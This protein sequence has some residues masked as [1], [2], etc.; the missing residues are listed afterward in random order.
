MVWNMTFIFPDIGNFIIP[1]DFHTFQ[2]GRYTT[3]QMYTGGCTSQYIG[4]IIIHIISALWDILFA[5]QFLKGRHFG[6]WTLLT[7]GDVSKIALESNIQYPT[8]NCGAKRGLTHQSST[9]KTI[10]VV[11][12]WRVHFLH[13]HLGILSPYKSEGRADLDLGPTDLDE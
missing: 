2:R 5:G 1:T 9:T 10:W 11:M 13:W 8:A 3:N 6:S 12:C 4:L 7:W